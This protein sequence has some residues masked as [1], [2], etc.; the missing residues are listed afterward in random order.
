MTARRSLPATGCSTNRP[1]HVVAAK[2][3]LRVVAVHYVADSDLDAAIPK[4]LAAA[5]DLTGA[6]G[7]DG[8]VEGHSSSQP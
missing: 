5:I 8:V 4:G 2:H 7:G 6:E 1:S 3:G